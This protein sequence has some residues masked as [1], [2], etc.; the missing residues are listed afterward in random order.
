MSDPTQ[1][2]EALKELYTTCRGC[3][4][5]PQLASARQNVVFGAGN[6]DADLMFVGEAPGKNED[7]QGLPFVGQAGK[8]LNQLLG[9]IGLERGDVFIANVLKCLDYKA[10][11]QLGD[12]S[13]ERIGRLVR[14]R[15]S[16]TVMSVDE[17]G[18]I[19]PR[20]VT[21]WHA[22]P[23]GGRSVHRLTYRSAENAGRSRS[24]INLTGDH[25]V[26]TERGYVPVEEL[27]D[28]DRIATGQG[29]SALA[30]D[31]VTGSLLGDASISARSAH[32]TMTHSERQA[33][34]ARF[35]ALLLEELWPIEQELRVAAVAGGPRDYGAI[36][37]RTLAH[38]ALGVLR[39]EFYRERKIVPRRLETGLNPRMLAI[40]FMDDGYTRIR[41][42]RQPLAEIAT[43]S[44][45]DGDLQVLLAALRRLGLPAKASRSRIY[46]DVAA[47]RALSELIAPYVPESMRYKLHPEV[48]ARVPFDPRR[49]APGPP[50]VVYDEVEV[51][52]VTDH[53]R[54]DRTF[55]C[56]DVEETHNFVTAGGVVHNC[57]PPGNRDPHPLE[58]DN[59][60][61][62]LF[63]QVAL[64]QPKVI[65]TLGNFA[66]KLLR[67]DQTGIT[68]VHGRDEV[69]VIGTRAVRLLPLYHPA[70]ALYTRSILDVLREDFA[71]IPDLLGRPAPEQPATAAP[72]EP[73]IP[74]PAL[75]AE[76]P[77]R[78]PEVVAASQLGLF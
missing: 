53:P 57:R 64:I 77:E 36:H 54:T 56:I 31:V 23:L 3:V 15:Y 51:E 52:D 11:V 17:E 42:T 75:A 38:R 49:Y 58:I 71:R 12:G 25:P 76:E 9:E 26:L 34:Y 66:T 47:T 37:V 44:F 33:E 16:G 4:R 30:R 20:R 78:E 63:D 61:G 59:C 1:R 13:W 32:L 72:P 28:G 21:G 74:E 5:C 19:V 39:E 65:C 40:W 68:R 6:A 18:R 73:A 2:R 69:R 50:E 48:E 46:F 41:D 70:A 27:A 43:V 24:G 10:A 29:L 45:D 35:K 22:T 60:Q 8:L 14:S 67:A 62:Y 55:F 7:E